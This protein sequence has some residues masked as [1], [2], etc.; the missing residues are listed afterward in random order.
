MK[1]EQLFVLLGKYLN[2]FKIVRIEDDPFIKGQINLWTH[3]DSQS[4]VIGDTNRV[5]FFVNAED[6]G[7][8]V[9]QASINKE[10]YRLEVE[11]EILKRR[12][13]NICFGCEGDIELACRYL[14]KLG[15]VGYDDYANQYVNL[16][17]DDFFDQELRHDKEKGENNEVL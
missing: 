11:N 14:H 7:S 5:K 1:K 13:N 8:P 2:G 15:Y 3:S 16:H 4:V 17:K 12:L 6:D 10:I 9:Y